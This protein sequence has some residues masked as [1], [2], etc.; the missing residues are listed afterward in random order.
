M[1]E[2]AKLQESVQSPPD[3]FKIDDVVVVTKPEFVK[4]VGYPLS[5]EEACERI[6]LT[7]Q[8]EIK[9]FLEE[10]SLYETEDSLGSGVIGCWPPSGKKCWQAYSRLVKAM[11]SFLLEKE[12]FGGKERAI[13]TFRDD[14]CLGLIA[15]VI[16]KRVV[17]TGLYYP[18]YSWRNHEN[19]W[20]GHPG[21]LS[22]MKTHV[23]LELN[24][25]IVNQYGSGSYWIER[26]NVTKY[27][28][29]QRV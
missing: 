6:E 12:N 19:E 10:T 23:L 7:K 9:K 20:D 8:A 28:E 5:F 15:S 2:V 26:C 22:N 14:R 11:A 3:R 16:N 13:H 21:G 29:T 17:K 25:G 1:Y 24:A 4:R 18:P 27:K